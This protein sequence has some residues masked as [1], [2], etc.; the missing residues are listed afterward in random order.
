M[1][2]L[3]KLFGGKRMAA[4]TAGTKAPPFEL[5]TT[6]GTKFSLADSLTRGPVVAAFFKIS[7][8]VCQYAFPYWERI[9]KSYGNSGK[10][11]IVGIS[12][13]EKN[14]TV[15]FNRRSSQSPRTVS[16]TSKYGTISLGCTSAQSSPASTQW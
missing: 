7:C 2:W 9:Y 4:L 8:P 10:L 3:K 13:N 5:L 15:E 1:S 16:S 11:T 14:D 6:N 12:Q